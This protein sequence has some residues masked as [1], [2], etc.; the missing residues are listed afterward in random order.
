MTTNETAAQIVQKAR[1]AERKLATIARTRRP[2]EA[3]TQEALAAYAAAAAV[4]G[5]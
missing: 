2:T 4:T 1:D 3:E 5:R